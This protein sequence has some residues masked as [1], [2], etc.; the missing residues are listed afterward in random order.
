MDVN[1]I[2]AL[3][4]DRDH[5]TGFG[6]IAETGRVGHA[7]KFVFDDGLSNLKRL[8]HHGGE[9]FRI[10]PVGNNEEF[11]VEEPIRPRRE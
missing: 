3:E 4:T 5:L 10:G 9:C 7:D 1:T 11:A 2:L 6:V 8:G